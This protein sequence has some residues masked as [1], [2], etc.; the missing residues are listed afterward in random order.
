MFNKTK[1]SKTNEK[2]TSIVINQPIL[3]TDIHYLEELSI[4]LEELRKYFPRYILNPTPLK[5]G[6]I[7]HIWLKFILSVL[8]MLVKIFL[9]PSLMSIKNL[10]REEVKKVYSK[11]AA[12]YNK[13]HHLTT[14]GMDLIWRR[15]AGWLVSVIGRNSASNITILDLCTGTGLTI[16]EILPFL[17]DWGVTADIIGFDYN[18]D[19]LE[20]ARKTI[21]NSKYNLF[22]LRGDAMDL[23][24]DTESIKNGL[25]KFKRNFFN[26]VTQ[27]CGIGGIEKPLEVFEGV[28]QILKPGGRFLMVD[29]HKPIPEQPGEWPF[30]LKW[31]R[32]PILEAF[33]YEKGTIPLVLNQLWGWRDTTLC[34]YFLPLITYQ[35][36]EGKYW[37]FKV[38][39]FE[40]EPQR[41]L[42][43]LPIISV[44]KIVVEK[45][46]INKDTEK[47][48]RI[49]LQACGFNK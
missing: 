38:Q 40:V 29:M 32:F 13:K 19:M 3:S 17:N 15:L 9:R 33:I 8:A 2:H 24:A 41:W 31:Y 35:D 43:A 1:K 22:F 11:Q 36:N 37:G 16:K 45:V 39:S 27:I 34:F 10:N 47:T 20:I 23:V 14:Y 6:L 46:E 21:V 30:F 7:K 12:T 49:I 26:I 25:S 28:L 48:R 4:F 18:P 5:C 42:F 44:G